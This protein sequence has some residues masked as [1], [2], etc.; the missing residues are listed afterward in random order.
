LAPGHI[1]A[2]AGDVGFVSGAHFSRRF[3]EAYGFSPRNLR[4]F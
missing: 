2:I 3:I 4:R 1:G